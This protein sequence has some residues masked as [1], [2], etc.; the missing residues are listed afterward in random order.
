MGTALNRVNGVL[1]TAQAFARGGL[2]RHIEEV[3]LTLLVGD[4]RRWATNELEGVEVQELIDEPIAARADLLLL[5][6]IV[7]NLV[8]NAAHAVRQLPSP[9]VRLH[10]Y[11]SNETAVLSVRDNGPGI[12]PE[13]RDR[14]FEPF[15]TTRRGQGGTGLGLALCQEYAAQMKAHI[16]LWTAPGRGACFRIHLRRAAT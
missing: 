12:S 5:R 13:I 16:T 6:Q 8:T 14:I 11:G 10:V 7:L 15:F 2:S 1:A 3:D 4:V 9:R